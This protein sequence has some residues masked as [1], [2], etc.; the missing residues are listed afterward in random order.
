MAEV[1]NTKETLWISTQH[2]KLSA[3]NDP[4]KIKEIGIVS[5]D[6]KDAKGNYTYYPNGNG[7]ITFE[8]KTWIL[9]VSHSMHEEDGLND[10]TLIRTSDGKFY[11]NKGHVCGKLI[12]ETKEKIVSLETFLKT[13]GKAGDGKSTA[14]ENYKDSPL[15]GQGKTLSRPDTP[16]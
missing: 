9:I 1:K 16:A 7:K 8:D 5:P 12:L 2:K 6:K 4:S 14:W 10:I 15:N 11:T 13:T 3:I